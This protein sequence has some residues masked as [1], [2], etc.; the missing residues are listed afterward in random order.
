MKA[1]IEQAKEH[2]LQYLMT[3]ESCVKLFIVPCLQR[4]YE[5]YSRA[6]NSAKIQQELKKRGIL[7]R[8]EVVSNEPE[9][10]IATIEDA[11]N[12]RLDNYL[13]KRGLGH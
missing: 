8:V 5:D 11:A 3:A 9:I 10:I 4:D 6:M 13:R 12:G 1:P 2:I 7:G